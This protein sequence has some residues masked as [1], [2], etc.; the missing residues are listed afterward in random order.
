MQRNQKH[1]RTLHWLLAAADN[2]TISFHSIF[3][4]LM[5]NLLQFTANDGSDFFI[6]VNEPVLETVTTRGGNSENATRG[7]IQNAKESFDKAIQPLKEISNSI[8]DCIKEISHSPKEIQVELG[9]KFSAKAGIILT[10]LDSEANLKITLKWQNGNAD[11][12]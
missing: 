4:F 5:K 1:G 11:G 12:N 7:V 10:S 8:I 9:L 3:K 2:K 6:E